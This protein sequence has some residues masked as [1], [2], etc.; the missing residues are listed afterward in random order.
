MS[1]A[2]VPLRRAALVSLGIAVFSRPQLA[3]S[4][5][6]PDW[7]MDPISTP[8]VAGEVAAMVRWDPDGQ[9]PLS[10]VIVIG[11]QWQGVGGQF[12]ERRHVAL[13]TR[14]ID[15]HWPHRH[16]VDVDIGEAAFRVEL[17]APVRVCRP[18]FHVLR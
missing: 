5:C 13:N 12:Y 6:I 18:R 10:P 8:G 14:P 4:Q 15:K 16:P 3:E 1:T 9:G 2:C 11:G 17:G 7:Q